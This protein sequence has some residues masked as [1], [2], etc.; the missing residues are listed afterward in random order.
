MLI[1]VLVV[2]LTG[3]SAGINLLTVVSERVLLFTAL[4]DLFDVPEPVMIAAAVS[5]TR[6]VP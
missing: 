6:A 4:V 1:E 3:D 5:K 2:M